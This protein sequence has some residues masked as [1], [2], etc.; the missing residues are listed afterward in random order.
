MVDAPD[1]FDAGRLASFRTSFQGDIVLPDDA[2]YDV[3]LDSLAA[4]FATA[5]PTDSFGMWAQGG[6]I[7]RVAEDA[8]AF[9]GRAARFQMSAE[10][11]WDDSNLDASHIGWAR[12]A[13]AILEPYSKTGRYVNDV[14]DSVLDLGRWI[15]GDAKYDRLVAVKRQWDPENAFRLNQNIK[16]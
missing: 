8:M 9:T 12:A 16:P 6:A 11:A 15:Y 3:A 2:A 1:P 13:Y 4:H 10:S 14:S 7:A 5:T